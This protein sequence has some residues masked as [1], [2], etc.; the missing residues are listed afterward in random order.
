MKAPL[1]IYI[2]I[3][4]CIKKCNYCDF[5]SF[6]L[7]RAGFTPEEY[8]KALVRDIKGYSDISGR[9]TVDS[10]Y[11]GGGTPTL[12]PIGEVA[13]LIGE[14]G[15]TFDISPD[16]EI[17]MECNPASC[18]GEYLY[19]L[20]ELGVNRLSIGLQSAFDEELLRLGRAHSFGD[21][22][23]T[24]LDARTAGF[25]NISVDLMYAIP[26]SPP[27]RFFAT[28]EKVIAIGPEHISAYAL[29]IEQGTPFFDIKNELDLPDDDTQFFIYEKSVEKLCKAG[30]RRYEISN[31]AKVGRESRH[32][33][34]YWKRDEYLGFGVSAYS[35]FGGE[36]FGNSRDVKGFL[37][38]RDVR[39]QKE[40][41]GREEALEE[42]IML[43]LRLSDGVSEEEYRELWGRDLLLD[44]PKITDFV[45]AGYMEKRDGRVFFTDSGFFVSNSII[46]ELLDFEY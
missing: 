30:Y 32:N 36:R 7:D 37:E 15:A 42:Y 8:C 12:L 14:L 27:D 9:Y 28:L 19:A 18:D 3:P 40:R 38:G 24:F 1:G 45:R 22:E 34:K 16:A 41:I 31:F 46:A 26:E 6:P 2:H 13:S 44:C 17:T 4:F 39:I 21:F 35:F 5:C 23:R 43:G 11:F 10:I 20:S 29:K 25:E 33:L